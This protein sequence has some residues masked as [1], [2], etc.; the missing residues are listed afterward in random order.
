MW[1]LY[2]EDRDIDEYKIKF[3]RGHSLTELQR[4]ILEGKRA[5]ESRAQI[6][7]WNLRFG[8]WNQ[9]KKEGLPLGQ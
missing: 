2:T 4:L 7:V 9:D 8:L 6:L 1:F 5:R 3:L